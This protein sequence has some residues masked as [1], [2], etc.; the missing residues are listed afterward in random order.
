MHFSQLS[1]RNFR[2]FESVGVR[3]N[4][5]VN[6]FLGNNGQGK[7]NLVEGLHLLVKGT[8][9]RHG[10]GDVFLRKIPG[11]RAEQASVHG[12]VDRG[13]LL[14]EL[15]FKC[16][17]G[18]K[19]FTQ[20]GK[21]VAA[22]A[23]PER[24][25]AVLFSP[26]SLIAIKEGPDQRR[27]LIDDALQ[28]MG[29][30]DG[31]RVPDF[32]RALRSRNRMLKD[33]KAG[34]YSEN[35]VAALLEAFD[36]VYIPISATLAMS[37]LQLLKAME[38]KIRDAVRFISED[39]VDISVDYEISDLSAKEWDLSAIIEAHRNRLKLLRKSELS[40]GTSLVG[41]HKHEISFLSG[42]NDARYFCSQG[43]QR[44]LI[45]GFKMAQ[46]MYHHSVFQ[47]HPLLL[48]DDVLSELDPNKGAN[49]LKF[50]ESVRSQILLT[51]TD[52][53]FPFEFAAQGMSV[54]RLNAGVAE[55][56]R[57]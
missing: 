50:L 34:I 30:R 11:G 40:V 1:F 24:Y 43:Q 12:T 8:S 23:L 47:I 55:E 10:Q 37:R 39:L 20:D 21:K 26:E 7:T 52:I 18:H 28:S 27:L 16:Q 32:R 25:P 13:G 33:F 17:T 38:P 31:H 22:S 57:A 49:L 29:G 9:F 14:S 6:I 48:L 15:C 53:S 41:A 51:S 2:N 56:M 35:Q 5:G 19:S 36:E 4:P 45:L 46:I 44:T 42:G 3:L 54:F